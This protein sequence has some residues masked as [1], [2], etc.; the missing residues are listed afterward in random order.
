MLST[1]V[2]AGNQALDNDIPLVAPDKPKL[3]DKGALA[4]YAAKAEKI[5]NVYS[6]SYPSYS[7]D[8]R[9]VFF[10]SD[11]SGNSQLYKSDLSD[12]S[13]PPK[14]LTQL[15][16]RVKDPVHLSGENA[17]IF[18]SDKGANELWSIFKL[19]LDNGK[20]AELTPGE[21]MQRDAPIVPELGKGQMFYS[22]RNIGK[23]ESYLYTQSVK[24]GS[25]PRKFWTGTGPSV[26]L[27]VSRDGQYALAETFKSVSSAELFLINT[28]TGDARKIY[29]R[30]GH[31]AMFQ[32]G[33]FSKDG[34]RILLPT[35]DGGEQGILL[36]LDHQGKELARYT[37]TL[38]NVGR[39]LGV[40]VSPDDKQL[41][42]GF[43]A[44]DHTELR[45]LDANTLK[46]I[47]TPTLP[48]GTGGALGFSPDGKNVLVN[49]STPESP[50]DIYQFDIASGKM[51]VLMS[52]VK[53]GLEELPPLTT[54]RVEIPA[55]DGG[56][57]PMLV[58]RSPTAKGPLPVIVFF[59][60]GPA[61]ASKARWE[62]I[63]RYFTSIGYAYAEPNIR[64]STGYGR[65]Y[66]QADNG[67]KKVNVFKDMRSVATWIGQ[68]PWADKNRLVIAGQSYGGF[69]TLSGVARQSDLWA[70][71]VDK[72]GPPDLLS[73]IKK[74]SGAI[75]A[76][77][78]QE[79]GVVGKD[80]EF[81]L[82]LSP[83]S[84]LDKIAVPLFV[85]AGA[86]DPRVPRSESDMIVAAMR[87]KQLPVEY[88]V[89]DNEG[90]S[91]VRKEN[92]IEFLSRVT[93][94]LEQNLS[95][96]GKSK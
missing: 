79:Y 35:D 38:S 50:A 26:L 14:R 18:S 58:Y 41:V 27:D 65:A 12:P 81:L 31:T 72:Y 55:F 34:S 45:I 2:L 19:N 86:N 5:I 28:D 36:A 21:S 10:V 88:M 70:A 51:T 91:M 75:R 73:L 82:A 95:F 17:L 6:D 63:L 71:G 39:L 53:P 57:I 23:I 80:D 59:H 1:H 11:R 22:A 92:Q 69:I 89:A 8:G 87:A 62:P 40:S 60:G 30:E 67:P 90:H 20:I 32:S 66:E 29:P 78:G 48:F 4:Q 61:Y 16:E 94:F 54:E 76:V 15:S 46:P 49:W 56:K 37:E 68:Q 24:V 44:G 9:S 33:S 3:Q 83:I 85:Y 42:V 96:S 64:G 77:A 25:T 13:A 7:Q 52:T 47:M 74:T 84:H 43:D 93:L